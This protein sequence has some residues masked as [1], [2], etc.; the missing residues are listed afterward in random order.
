MKEFIIDKNTAVSESCFNSVSE[1]LSALPENEEEQYILKIAPG[2]YYE[3]LEIRRGNLIIEGCGAS[4]ED[5]ELTFDDCARKDHPDGNKYGTFRSYSVFIDAGNITVRNLTISNTSGPEDEAWQ[6]IAL[7]AEGNELR[8][9]NV[10]LC[11]HQD[12]LFTGPLPPK[13]IQPG[14]FIGPKQFAPRINGFQYYKNC[15]ICGNVDFIFGSATAFFDDCTIESIPRSILLRSKAKAQTSRD[16]ENIAETKAENKSDNKTETKTKPEEIHGYVT[17]G[18][19]PE[20]QEYGYTFRNCR[21]ISKECPADSVY[22]GRPWRDFAKAVFTDCEI[23]RHIRAEGFHD[24]N[25]PH[26]REVSY[27]AVKNCHRPD[28]TP[29][30]PTAD[31]CRPLP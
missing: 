7:Y 17:A 22:L 27:Y 6:A 3:K 19:T 15:Y 30:I 1:A 24:W 8:F 23:G 4:P 5:T 2:K 18:S 31:F 25:K 29:Y 10:R 28:G 20:G 16:K 13:E 9:E 14:G 11:G 12:T 21:F 26:A